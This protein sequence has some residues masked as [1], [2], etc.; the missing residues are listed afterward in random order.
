VKEEPRA[1]L[2]ES[3][4]LGDSF[5]SLPLCGAK[6]VNALSKLKKKRPFIQDIHSLSC[7]DCWA[8]PT[9]N[10]STIVPTIQK[11]MCLNLS[12]PRLFRPSYGGI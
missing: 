3:Y 11:Y 1:A 6:I 9:Q 8:T 5:S 12:L 4:P 2:L 10:Y 7:Y